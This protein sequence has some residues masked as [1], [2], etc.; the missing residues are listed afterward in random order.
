MTCPRK[1]ESVDHFAALIRDHQAAVWR[2]LRFL[3][4]EPGD[5]DDLTQETFLAVVDRPVHRFGEGGARAYLRTVARNFFLKLDANRHRTPSAVEL[6]LAEQ[7]F[8]WYRGEDE[9]KTTL[10][11]LRSCLPTLSVKGRR[12]LTH[13]YA[14]DLGRGAIAERMGLSAHGVKSLLQRSYAKLRAC[15][16]RRLRDAR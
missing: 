6:N 10:A 15:M 13:R 14:D 11:A 5:A 12:A 4:C 1:E 2:Y 7:A 9:G 16:E 3:G 8:D